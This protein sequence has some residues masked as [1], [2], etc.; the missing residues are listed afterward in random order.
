MRAVEVRKN[1]PQFARDD[2]GLGSM[3]INGPKAQVRAMAAIVDSEWGEPTGRNDG[4]RTSDM[5]IG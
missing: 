2:I 1:R 3:A 4:D 5:S